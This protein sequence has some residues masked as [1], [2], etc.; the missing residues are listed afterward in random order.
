M[1]VINKRPGFVLGMLFLDVN[2][3][4]FTAGEAAATPPVR[5]LVGGE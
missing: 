4:R 2:G 5:G 3:A 1:S